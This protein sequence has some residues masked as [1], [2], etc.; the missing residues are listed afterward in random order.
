MLL[1]V[2]VLT[3]I[4]NHDPLALPLIPVHLFTVQNITTFKAVYAAIAV[5]LS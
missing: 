2:H 3:G 1:C 5:T 4:I